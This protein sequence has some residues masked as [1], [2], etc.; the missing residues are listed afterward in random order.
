MEQQII[1]TTYGNICVYK[2]G[3]GEQSVV[4]IHGSGCDNAMLSWTEVIQ[5]FTEEYE[6][7]ALDLL[8]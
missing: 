7:Y 3:I 6:V 5:E 2:K 8:G 1:K 4:L